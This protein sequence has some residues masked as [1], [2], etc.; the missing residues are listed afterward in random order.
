MR[1]RSDRIH[2]V[3]FEL[4][5]NVGVSEEERAH[6]QRLSVNVTME[7][8]RPFSE[9]GDDLTQATDYFEACRT[10]E[11]IARKRPRKLIE[12]LAEEIADALLTQYAINTVEVEL[13][14][15]VISGAR[16]VAVEIQ[17]RQET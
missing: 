14:K 4:S 3:D 5:A 16:H 15:Y 2:I 11:M 13:R 10:I 8:I 7:P 9:L 17:R 6:P 12:T 1:T